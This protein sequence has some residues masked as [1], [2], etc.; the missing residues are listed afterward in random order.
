MA[1]AP[2]SGNGLVSG[3]NDLAANL[4]PAAGSFVIDKVT[5]VALEGSF[6]KLHAVDQK[7]YQGWLQRPLLLV[8]GK[9]PKIPERLE[10]VGVIFVK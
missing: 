2:L 5:S 3:F 6:L 10:Q 1:L 7:L 8:G 4:G 9:N